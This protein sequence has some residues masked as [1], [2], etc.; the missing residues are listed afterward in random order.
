MDGTGL[1]ALT[2]AGEQSRVV[3]LSASLGSPWFEGFSRF[4]S[5]VIFLSAVA[6][7]S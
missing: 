2:Q 7:D 1:A 6:V 4:V 5:E 3:F